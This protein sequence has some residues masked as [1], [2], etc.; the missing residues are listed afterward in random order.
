MPT[1]PAQSPVR[2]WREI[3]RE[4]TNET[5]LDRITEL[6]HELNRALA[7]QLFRNRNVS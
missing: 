5:N 7:E 3:S 1:D 2:P 4:L 6:H